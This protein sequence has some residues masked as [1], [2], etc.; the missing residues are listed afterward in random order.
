M[1]VRDLGWHRQRLAWEKRAACLGSGDSAR[2][3]A[4]KKLDGR[5]SARGSEPM[6]VR[7]RDPAVLSRG[8]ALLK[9][10]AD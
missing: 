5:G 6:L 1:K 9:M 8:R 4:K 2:E 10:V 3:A 7:A